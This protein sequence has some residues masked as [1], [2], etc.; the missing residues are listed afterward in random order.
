MSD[1]LAAV[2]ESS[3]VAFPEAI[4]CQE[5]AYLQDLRIWENAPRLWRSAF[6]ASVVSHAA[7][8]SNLDGAASRI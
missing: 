8:A 3:T 5:D 4:L 7:G 6:A 2:K 1:A